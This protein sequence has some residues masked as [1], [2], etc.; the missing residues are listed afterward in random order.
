MEISDAIKSVIAVFKGRPSD[1]FP[2]YVL[3]LSIPTIVRIVPLLGMS[4]SYLYLSEIG[5]LS[6]IRNELSNTDFSSPSPDSNPEAFNEWIQAVE[7]VFNIVFTPTVVLILVLSFII[8]FLLYI[9]V[10]SCISAGKLS[11]CYNIFKGDEPL[12]KGIIGVRHHWLTFLSLY[13]FE[14]LIWIISGVISLLL[15]SFFAE[16]SSVLVVI[17]SFVV[18]PV[19][20]VSMIIVRSIFTFAPVSVIVDTTNTLASLRRSFNFISENLMKSIAYYIVVLALF[21]GFLSFFATMSSVGIS[22]IPLLFLSLIIT[23]FLDLL[24]TA[25]YSGSVKSIEPVSYPDTNLLKQIYYAL[26]KGWKELIRFIRETP[27]IH[28]FSIFFGLLGFY[29]GWIMMEPF[30]GA[31]ETSI[32]SRIERLFFP[33]VIFEFF[34]NNLTVSLSTAYSGILLG[35]PSIFSLIFNGLLLGI[36]FKTETNFIELLAFI[37]PHGIFE[38]PAIIISGAVGLYLGHIGFKTIRGK[39]TIGRL[40]ES[41]KRSMWVL[42]GVTILLLVAGIIEGLISPFYYRL[43]L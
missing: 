8:S 29:L 11:V 25:L 31:I 23:P 27:V 37:I 40:T 18:F 34:G 13:I 20:V 5:Q 15:V 36:Y 30:V 10:S 1:L 42:I 41:L 9:F 21:F 19:W 33:I 14:F 6:D 12:K 28:I 7:G 35:I 43:F 17:V 22:S 32:N 3:G 4:I 39:E 24:K 16:F 2:F 38:I 26:N